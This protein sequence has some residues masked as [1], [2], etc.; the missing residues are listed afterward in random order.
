MGGDG[1]IAAG[2]LAVWV[3]RSGSS[4]PE[5]RP[6]LV[7]ITTLGDLPRALQAQPG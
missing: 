5:D 6:G 1:A 7:E 4:R 3:N 2:L